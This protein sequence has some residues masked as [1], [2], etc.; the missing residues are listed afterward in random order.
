M[1]SENVVIPSSVRNRKVYLPTGQVLQDFTSVVPDGRNYSETSTRTK[2]HREPDGWRRP[3]P[4]DL[5]FS[6]GIR[7][8]GKIE[9]REDGGTVLATL[10]GTQPSAVYLPPTRDLTS[11]LRSRAEVDALLKL[12]DQKINLGVAFAERSATAD[13]VGS[14]ATRL[15]KAYR[16]ARKGNLRKAAS[17][18]GVGLRKQT[19]NWLELQYGWKPLLSD[20]YGAAEALAGRNAP[21]AWNITVKGVA[22]NEERYETDSINGFLQWRYVDTY[23]GGAF[24][25][26]DYQPGNSFLST[27]S[28]L[29]LTNP[30]AIAWELVPYSFVVDWMWPIGD[31]LNALDAAN[32]FVLRGGSVSVISKSKRIVSPLNRFPTIGNFTNVSNLCGEGL[33][34]R[35]SLN[36]TVYSS[37]PLPL[38]PVPKNPVS[39]GHMANG[40]SLLAEAFGRGR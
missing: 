29:G 35:V 15:A 12:K 6:V 28:S 27:V 3:L 23:F 20:V 38:P 33:G 26:L 14:T 31:W 30:L 24:V 37:S 4:Y 10:D 32:G 22:K 34:R 1:P 36:R 11:G 5:G 8:R 21:R 40:L 18:L 19:S 13:L 2:S 9:Y 25:R 39:L 16:E 7:P 17:Q